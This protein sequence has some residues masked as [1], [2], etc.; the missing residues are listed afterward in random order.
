M[1]QE[2]LLRVLRGE[3]TPFEE[4][5]VKAWRAEAP[6]HAEA[7]R[8]LVE[9]W[10]N[11]PSFPDN[12]PGPPAAVDLRREA[13]GRRR[14]ARVA[15]QTLRVAALAASLAVAVG[16]S[17]Y[18]RRATLRIGETEFAA[19]PR[20]A[21][22]VTLTDGSFVRLAPSSSVFVD[23]TGAPR[24][25]RLEGRAFFAIAEDAD[26]PFQVKTSTGEITVIGTRFEVLSDESDL[27]LVVVDGRVQ[28]TTA[29]GQATVG[30]SEVADVTNGGIPIVSEIADPLSLLDWPDGLLVFQATPLA[31]VTFEIGRQ[32]GRNI[33]ISNPSLTNLTVTAVFED[34]SFEEVSEAVCLIVGAECF[35]QNSIVRMR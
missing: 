35:V 10:E 22:T 2:T 5:R 24:H 19:G 30:A 20:D 31:Q 17:W 26:R 6:D 8:Q 4:R 11:A 34:Q 29:N 3:A 12:L 15:R 21:A 7:Y 1:D 13:D 9:V 28:L 18:V 32:F 33:E 23:A 27:R 16:T 14:R 25:V